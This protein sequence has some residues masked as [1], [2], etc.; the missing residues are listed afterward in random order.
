MPISNIIGLLVLEKKILKVFAI[1]SL[2]DH[3]TLTIYIN[4]CSFIN[5]I[6]DIKFGF[7]G[8]VVT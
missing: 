7:I 6:L 2:G 8:Q 5:R 3:V 1:K 4:F